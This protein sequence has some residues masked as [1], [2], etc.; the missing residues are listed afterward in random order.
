MSKKENRKMQVICRY[1]KTLLCSLLLHFHSHPSSSPP[2][3]ALRTLRASVHHRLCGLLLITHALPSPPPPPPLPYTLSHCRTLP[4]YSQSRHIPT[5]L[6][7]C[8][9]TY[10]IFLHARCTQ[11]TSLF[12]AQPTC[13]VHLFE[14]TKKR[15]K[16]THISHS[17]LPL[18]TSHIYCPSSPPFV[19]SFLSMTNFCWHLLSLSCFFLRRLCFRLSF[20]S[21]SKPFFVF[22]FCMPLRCMQHSSLSFE[23]NEVQGGQGRSSNE[24][25]MHA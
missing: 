2:T 5:I 11:K 9:C 18:F 14:N 4:V 13:R 10:K 24:I 17:P 15:Q 19:T 12:F 16:N 22:S 21:D 7:S 6:H 20:P 25:E 8:F 23:W 3:L 1:I